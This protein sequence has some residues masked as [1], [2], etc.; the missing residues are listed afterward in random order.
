[1]EIDIDLNL[2]LPETKAAVLDSLSSNYA[3]QVDKNGGLVRVRIEYANGKSLVTQNDISQPVSEFVEGLKA[4]VDAVK[5]GE[6]VLR[7]AVYYDTDD[8]VT[9]S[10]GLS[11]SCLQR[12]AALG[13]ALDM[14]VYPCSD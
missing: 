7:I 13:L 9:V 5:T 3:V 1:M 6:G 10:I 2:Q 11:K 14:T 12:L 4:I 8:Q